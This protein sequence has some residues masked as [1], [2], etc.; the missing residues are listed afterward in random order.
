MIF[1]MMDNVRGMPGRVAARGN[2]IRR[3]LDE[4]QARLTETR[5]EYIRWFRRRVYDAR[6]SGETQLWNLHVQTLEAANQLLE[7]TPEHPVLERVGRS[8]RDLVEAVERATTHPP[9]EGYVELNVRQ[10][11]SEIRDLDRFGLLRVHRFE[12]AHKNRKTI[13]NAITRELERRAR[14]AGRV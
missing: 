5:T 2:D 12:S 9:I 11:M 6:E 13:L 14:L 4:Q 1:S 3:T 10:V 7:N 8:A